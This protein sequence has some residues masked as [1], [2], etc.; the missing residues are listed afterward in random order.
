[1]NKTFPL[2]A[3]VASLGGALVFG[4]S[5]VTEQRSTQ[6]V[7]SR[8][9]LSPRLLLDLVRQPAWTAAIGATL[10]GFALQVVALRFG[11]LALVEPIL[12]CDLIFAVLINSFLRKRWDPIMIAGVIASSA[13]LAAFLAIARPSGGVSTV[14]FSDVVPVLVGLALAVAGSIALGERLR[15]IRPL[16][17]ALACGISYGF[18][19][20]TVK[21]VTNQFGGGLHH[22]FS[23]WPIYVV[24]VVGPLGFLL[25]QNAFQQGTL[26]S[27]VMAIITACDPLISIALGF[28]LLKESLSSSPAAIAGQVAALV[29]MTTG[30]V[31]VA[32]HAPQVVRQ[33]DSTAVAPRAPAAPAGSPADAA[34]R[35][36][37]LAQALPGEADP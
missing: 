36:D 1:V 28:F 2:I 16:T 12:V 23:E 3:V 17:L 7:K 26:L 34:R 37:L 5:S 27:P 24:A 13:G 25:N 4:V 35:S 11:P 10:V 14:P 21:L 30:I 32:H 15:S 31:I 33:L 22:L 9:T 6:R 18:A 29:V 19:A 20:F 8:Q